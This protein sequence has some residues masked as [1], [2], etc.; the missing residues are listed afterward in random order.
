[1]AKP[2]EKKLDAMSGCGLNRGPFVTLLL[3]DQELIQMS[4]EEA[5][6]HAMCVLE[7]AESAE[8]DGF[9]AT[10]VKDNFV[11]PEEPPE[12]AFQMTASILK[13]F[14]EFRDKNRKRAVN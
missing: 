13:H 3:N 11:P 12:A 8:T 5:R 7:A 2:K 10:Y 9:I 4:V 1:M 6:H 14:R